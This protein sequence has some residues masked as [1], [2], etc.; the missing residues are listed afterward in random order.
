MLATW[1]LVVVAQQ[2]D[3]IFSHKFHIEDVDA[4]C[5]NCHEN[6]LTSN[7]PQDNQLP[8]METCYGCHDESETECTLCHTDPDAAGE[9][10]RITGLKANFAHQKHAQSFNDCKK[11]HADIFE[12]ESPQAG[13]MV[14]GQAECMDCHG[15]FDFVEEK[16]YCLTCHNK[17]L[18]F[19]PAS[20]SLTWR[21]SHGPQGQLD[22]QSCNHCHNNNYCTNC[23]QGDNLDRQSHPL[24][25]KFNHG[26][27]AR[28]NKDNCLT[29]HEESSS[30]IDCHQTELVMPKNHSSANWATTQKP[31]GQHAR[32]A[33]YD[34][35]Y[36]SSCHN[37]A[38]SDNVCLRCHM[39]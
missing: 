9:A 22:E 1:A 33:L 39:E 38:Y 4:T 21:K 12:S 37:D 34:F 8:T 11:C 24:N 32:A 6:V 10:P 19:K 16:L 13:Q 28:A 15:S 2:P 26:I 30:C 27:Q 36:C 29:C 17:D 3:L 23:H 5:E 20:H 35:D 18:E 7:S 31:G 25:F 14:P